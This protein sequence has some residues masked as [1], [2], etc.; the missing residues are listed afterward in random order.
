MQDLFERAS[1]IKNSIYF[2]Q[3]KDVYTDEEQNTFGRMPI[4]NLIINSVLLAA[5]EKFPESVN[6]TVNRPRYGSSSQLPT[7]ELN[8]QYDNEQDLA[9]KRAEYQKF[10]NDLA[11]GNVLELGR[12]M[13]Y[14]RT[15]I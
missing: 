6:I 1:F 7:Y 2:L 12:V 11:S 10:L 5:S 4:D 14:L 13:R 3:N 9:K 8:F 15:Q